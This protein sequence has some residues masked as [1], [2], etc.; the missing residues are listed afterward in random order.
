[1]MFP[2]KYPQLINTFGLFHSSAYADSE[3]KKIA[4]LKAINFIKHNGAYE[5]LKTSIPGLFM[6]QSS[7][8]PS[9][10]LITNTCNALIEKGKH[11]TP[12]VLIHYYQA[13]I[14]RPDRT[15]VLK[16][17]LHPILFIMGKHDVAVP[18]TQ[19]M[20]QS[21]LPN[22]SYITILRNSAHM[23]MWEETNKANTA[24]LAFLQGQPI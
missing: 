24:L 16:N 3:E 12:E 19:S 10:A 20:Q 17:F 18:F 6:P 5:F 2:K 13:M 4:R 14:G 8:E 7:E 11:F 23:G 22:T 15:E 1:M 21:Y 9:N